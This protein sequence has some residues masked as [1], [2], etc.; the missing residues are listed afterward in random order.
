MLFEYICKISKG[1]IN[2]HSV[3]EAE[4]N[5][6]LFGTWDEKINSVIFYSSSIAIISN[7]RSELCFLGIS[8]K[9]G[10]IRY[11]SAK[12][13]KFNGILF[14]TWDE[15]IDSVVFSQQPKT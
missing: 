12:E 9:L 8:P 7:I 1:T 6:I 15:K 5:G 13:A 3:K 10:T 4:F 11:H 14:G 2:Y